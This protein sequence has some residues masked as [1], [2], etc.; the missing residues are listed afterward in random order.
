VNRRDLPFDSAVFPF[1]LKTS[2]LGS[3][4]YIPTKGHIFAFEVTQLPAFV[5]I[6]L[7][8]G[9]KPSPSR[10]MPI[11]GSIVKRITPL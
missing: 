8:K 3:S 1:H 10:R 7:K 9:H 5:G 6:E 2:Q 4:S 11:C